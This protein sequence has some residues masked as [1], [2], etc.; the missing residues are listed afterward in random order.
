MNYY[1]DAQTSE[2]DPEYEA[3]L[4]RQAL[5]HPD[6]P[7]P[8]WDE[9]VHAEAVTEGLRRLSAQHSR[10]QDKAMDIAVQELA[11]QLVREARAPEIAGRALRGGDFVLGVPVR[12]PAIWGAGERVLWAEGEGLVVAGP[13]GVGKTT[14]IQQVILG[15]IGVGEPTMLGLPVAPLREDQEV[16][17]LAM[18][19]P[20]QARRSLRRMVKE[21]DRTVLERRLIGWRG[22]LPVDVVGNPAAFADFVCDQGRNVGA[23]VVDSLKD[24]ATGIAKDDVSAAVNIAFQEVLARDVGLLVSHHTRKLNGNKSPTIDDVFGGTWVTAGAG[25]VVMLHGAPGDTAVDF[26]HL[27]KPAA[28]VG[29]LKL[30]HDH[31]AGVTRIAGAGRTVQDLLKERGDIGLTLDEAA[32]EFVGNTEKAARE[33]MRRQLDKLASDDAAVYRPG[34]RGGSG[35]G[36]D[37]ARWFSLR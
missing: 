9:Q 33:K 11:R 7:P 12:P 15:L 13:T 22:P 16:L 18:D 36:G 25:S 37:P 10:V 19:R 30:V 23:V 29:P 14:L 35:G 5:E 1:T 34:T 32:A 31:R 24:M 28:E 8:G 6:E 17:Y 21:G 26:R 2:L 3:W 4:E 20:D 27:K